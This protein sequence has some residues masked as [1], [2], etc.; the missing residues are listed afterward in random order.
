MNYQL[1][2]LPLIKHEGGHCYISI[3]PD[4]FPSGDTA[5]LQNISTL[6]LF[7]NGCSIGTPHSSHEE[8]RKKGQG[9][10]SHWLN[11]LRFSVP[12]NSNPVKN[13]RSYY[14]MFCSSSEN[15]LKSELNE[16]IFDFNGNESESEKYD[17][18]DRVLTLLS[19]KNK[20]SEYGRIFFNDSD[21]ISDFESFTD[22]NYRSLDRK[23]TVYQLCKLVKSIK[24]DTAE[25]GVYYGASSHFIA[26]TTKE[27][28]LNKRH[29]IFDSFEGVST[30]SSEDAD[31]WSKGDMQ[32]GINT[33]KNN[34]SAFNFIDYHKGWIPERF[35]EVEDISFS[36]VHLDVD[37]YQPT[38][39]SVK[40]FY[41]KLASGGIMLCDDYGFETC[42]GAKQAMDE[43]FA[44]KAED[45]I[46]LPTGQAFIQK[47]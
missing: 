6:V 32:V 36:F 9:L 20:L 44:D 26:K 41:F 25:C 17:L 43:F 10:Y 47:K 18:A 38:W 4:D 15:T 30:P 28:S 39:D 46:Q 5:D 1:V 40:F 42:P 2:K 37:L 8:I 31:Y 12:D 35:N 3:L 22:V 24:G 23:Y 45:I 7:E 14:I 11:T 19:P 33:V 16:I 21:F 27:S 34:L 29:H 13:K